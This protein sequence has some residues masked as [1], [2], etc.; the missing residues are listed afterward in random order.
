VKDFFELSDNERDT[1]CD[2]AASE[3]A[4]KIDVEIVKAGGVS[5][6]IDKSLRDE[7][8]MYQKLNKNDK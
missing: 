6:Y 1:L 5:N 2:I 4:K 3:I 8:S 7:I